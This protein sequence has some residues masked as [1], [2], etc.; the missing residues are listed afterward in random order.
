MGTSY[1]ELLDEAESFGLHVEERFL[2]PGLCGFY[3]DKVRTV[4]LDEGMLE[5]QKRCTLC[6][7]LAH[8]QY[9][10]MGCGGVSETKAE[11]RARR[12]AASRL[13]SP[14]EYASAE[15]VYEGDSYLI[16]CELD[17]TVQLVEDYRRLVLPRI[18]NSSWVSQLV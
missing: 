15:N 9:H 10:D 4:V 12:R 17:V 7:E 14:I 16:A 3:F 1:T 8:A 11:L 13:I 2:G 6:H 18:I 5:F